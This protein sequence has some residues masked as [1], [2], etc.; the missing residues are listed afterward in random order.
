[1]FVEI[2]SLALL[3]L[4]PLMVFETGVYRS[5]HTR[6]IIGSL[7]GITFFAIWPYTQYMEQ[8]LLWPEIYSKICI[9]SM[10]V[11]FLLI[12]LL[13]IRTTYV[14]LVSASIFTLSIMII[15]ISWMFETGVK[16]FIDDRFYLLPVDS[17]GQDA[18]VRDDSLFIY[19]HQTGGYS[20]EIPKFW[21][22]KND[23][24][25]Q[26]VYF[27]KNINNISVEL[28]PM[29]IDKTVTTLG[30]IV[31]NIRNMEASASLI[32]PEINCHKSKYNSS[33]CS[34]HYYDMDGKL[35]KLSWFGFES[36]IQK[37]YF[38]DFILHELDTKTLEEIKNIMASVRPSERQDGLH[39]CLSLSGWF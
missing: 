10:C 24:G 21:K 5:H 7:F 9:A 13:L 14:G 8:L 4:A 12:A 38:L 2:R 28:R 6:I 20:L 22:R 1:M 36:D 23:Y 39:D 26:F 34:V 19:S 16:H 27:K 32:T 35:K 37:G 18:G 17:I 3:A 11:L 30:Q 15:V 29:C 33:S 25:E 31:I